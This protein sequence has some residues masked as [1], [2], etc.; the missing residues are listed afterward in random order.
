MLTYLPLAHGSDSYKNLSATSTINKVK[1]SGKQLTVHRPLAGPRMV[2]TSGP[3]QSGVLK[4]VVQLLIGLS[5]DCHKFSE[6]L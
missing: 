4:L 3:S 6:K 5:T 2:R 1:I